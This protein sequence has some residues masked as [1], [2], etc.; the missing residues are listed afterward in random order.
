MVAKAMYAWRDLDLSTLLSH[1]FLL[2]RMH[3]V[4]FNSLSAAKPTSLSDSMLCLEAFELKAFDNNYYAQA[5]SFQKL[6]WHVKG[7][8][9]RILGDEVASTKRS[10]STL[11]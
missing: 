11:D 1:L 6:I 4:S 3:I 7:L 2:L 5:S 9:K 8:V 10:S